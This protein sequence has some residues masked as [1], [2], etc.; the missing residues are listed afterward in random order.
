MSTGQVLTS[1]KEI[2]A[3]MGKGVRTVQRWESEMELPVRRPGADR[4]I[5]LAFPQEL[6]AWARRQLERPPEAKT[7]PKQVQELHT[8]AQLRRMRN[9]VQI[10]MDRLETNRA[11]AEKL[12]QQ[13]ET[14]RVAAKQR[15]R[16]G[17]SFAN[18]LSQTA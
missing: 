17:S 4:H 13:C 18:R 11:C 9:L 7:T 6:D 14:S 15:S 12:R 16:E 10:M 1:W 3:Y 2:A 5:V 8:H